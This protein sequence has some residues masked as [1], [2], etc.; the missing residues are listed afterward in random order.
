MNFNDVR[1]RVFSNRSTASWIFHNVHGCIEREGGGRELRIHYRPNSN[2]SF[3]N[4][5][6]ENTV[7]DKLM[8]SNTDRRKRTYSTQL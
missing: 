8:E 6:K 1:S 7:D 3:S 5:Q 4:L 2:I